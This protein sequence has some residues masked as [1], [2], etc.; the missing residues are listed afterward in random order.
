MNDQ[1]KG[2]LLTFGASAIVFGL[3]STSPVFAQRAT[4]G[5]SEQAALSLGLSGGTVGEV[6][7]VQSFDQNI[8]VAFEHPQDALYLELNPQSVR[9]DKYEVRVQ[10]ADGSWE[11]APTQPSQTYRGKVLGYE[12]S[13]VAA[14]YSE[15]GLHARIQ[16]EDGTEFWIEPSSRGAGLMPGANHTLYQTDQVVDLG[17]TCGADRIDQF[18]VTAAPGGTSSSQGVGAPS[19]GGTQSIAAGTTAEL[20][21]DT[22]YEY[23]SDWGSV[24]ATTARIES[25][26]NTMNLQYE[27]DVD[28]T[29]AITTIL[30][31]SS[32]NDPYSKKKADQALFEVRDEWNA[33]QT[34]VP[35][36]VTQFFTGKT[37][38]GSTIGIAWVGQ[39]CNL[40]YAYSL[41]ESD[42]NGNFASSTDLSA[43]E[44]GHNWNAGHCSCTTY[45]MN[46]FIVNANRFNPSGTIPTI[47]SYRDAQSCFGVVDPPEDP[48]SINVGAISTGTQSAGQGKKHARATV[49]IVTDTGTAEAGAT[50]Q[51]TFSGTFNESVSGVTDGS[52]NVTFLT[53]ETA[54]GNVSV[55]FC[56]DSVNGSLP[57]IPGNNAATCN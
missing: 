50:V 34:G 4:S 26:I 19:L 30:V 5:L 3:L 9:S 14:S 32:S 48:V 41:V 27:R 22:D 36:D 51:G 35:R 11:V 46:P 21:C 20:A 31:R 40:D 7:L 6:Q 28:I 47:T 29:H 23:F 12:N 33:N 15:A 18:V 45:T 38:V 24:G 44:L 8:L 16:L 17:R 43:H 54:K 42:F 13:R 57:Y 52:G 10:Q 53:T 2:Q 49:S 25:I 55:T 56:V 39:V 1:S 37:M